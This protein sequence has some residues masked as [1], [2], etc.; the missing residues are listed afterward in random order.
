MEA[1]RIIF[2]INDRRRRGIVP[3][4]SLQQN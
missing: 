1:Q 3:A 4:S 2:S